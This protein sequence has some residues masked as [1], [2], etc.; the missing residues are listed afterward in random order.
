M[1]I[2]VC[3][4]ENQKNQNR[5]PRGRF[6]LPKGFP[7]NRLATCRTNRAM[8]PQ[9]SFFFLRGRKKNLGKRKKMVLF[10]R[11]GFKFVCGSAFSKIGGEN[12][13]E[14]QT[15]RRGKKSFP[16]APSLRFGFK[17]VCGAN[18]ILCCRTSRGGSGRSA[19]SLFC[20]SCPSGRFPTFR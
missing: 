7:P 12:Q 5:T 11:F 13:E 6:E 2:F 1:F 14:P 3:N 8:R 9:H 10:W 20:F 19:P 16:N 15:E 17:F 4:N 18:S